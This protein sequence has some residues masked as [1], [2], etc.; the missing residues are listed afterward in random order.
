MSWRIDR[1]RVLTM[2]EIQRVVAE[3]RRL[4]RRSWLSYRKL[5]LFRLACCC[6]LRVGELT[7]LRLGDVVLGGMRPHL[8][9]RSGITKAD[10]RGR[11]RGRSVPL[12]WDGGTLADLTGWCALRS[13]DGGGDDLVI[14]TRSGGRVD[15]VAARRA[16]I[17]ACRGLGRP[18]TVHDGRHSFA[19]HAL[20]AGRSLVEVRDA[21]GHRNLGTTSIYAHLVD[22]L[23]E[24]VGELFGGVKKAAPEIRVFRAGDPAL[25][26]QYVA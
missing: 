7:Q 4:S 17:S 8:V 20:A 2:V 14:C 25:A 26:F 23:D 22:N 18:V 1:T 9:I 19:S 24:P 5:A 12:W 3:L 15:I 21:L 10:S 13:R 16:F 11:R 6:G